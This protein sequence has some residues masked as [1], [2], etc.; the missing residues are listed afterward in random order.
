MDYR[1]SLEEA[2][3]RSTLRTW[4]VEHQ[5]RGPR[6]R[7][8]EDRVAEMIAWQRALYQGGWLGLS[9]PTDYGGRGLPAVYEAIFNEELAVA[10]APA[11]PHIGFLGRALLHYGTEEQKRRYLPGL[12]SGDEQWCQGFSEPGAGSDLAALSTR[13]VLDGDAYVVDGQKIWT[14]DAQFAG[15]CL[16]LAGP[17]V[18]H[19]STGGSRASW[20]ICTNRGSPC[21]HSCRSRG[22]RSSTRCSSTAFGYP[23]SIWS[24]CLGKGGR[25]R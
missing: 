21:G 18:R 6:P 17:I 10:G 7:T 5:P 12:L 23:R 15:W 14:S 22:A 16:L 11:A 25:L 9:W 1:D 2:E 19:R 4:I 13:A 24:G 3:F 20:S 8:D